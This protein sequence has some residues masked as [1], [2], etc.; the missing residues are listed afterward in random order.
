MPRYSKEKMF[1]NLNGIQFYSVRI[2]HERSSNNVKFKV[3]TN[4]FSMSEYSVIYNT[5]Y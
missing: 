2:N 1:E 4:S 3:I 5:E